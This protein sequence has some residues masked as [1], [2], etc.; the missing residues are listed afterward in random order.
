MP[1]LTI[2]VTEEQSEL[3]DELSSDGGRYESKSEAVRSFI[4][5]G[6]DTEEL[7]REVER[8]NRERRQLLEQREENQELVEFA[9][10]TKSVLERREHR[11]EL[12]RTAPVWRRALWWVLGEPE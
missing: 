3:L 5:S 11:N 1:R 2:T 10:E 9:S 6:E 12:K 8:L 7:R 4:E